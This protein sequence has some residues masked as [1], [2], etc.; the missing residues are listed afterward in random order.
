[1][2]YTNP[3]IVRNFPIFISSEEL[4]TKN[5]EDI[6]VPMSNRKWSSGGKV[7][8][9]SCKWDRGGGDGGGGAQG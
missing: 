4:L 2:I 6:R 8:A 5:D 1:M 7:N 3:M 9:P